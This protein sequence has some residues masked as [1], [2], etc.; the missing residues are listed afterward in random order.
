MANTTLSADVNHFPSITWH[1][2]HI[3]HGHFEGTVDSGAE[4]KI[5]SL[6]N[7]IVLQKKR[8]SEVYGNDLHVETQLG[9][10]FDSDI[11][12]MME[13]NAIPVNEFTVEANKKC[14]LPVKISYIPENGTFTAADTVIVAESGSESTFIFEYTSANDAGGVFGNR[15]RVH[16]AENAVVHI[17]TVNILGKGIVHY[18]GIGSMVS[19]SGRVDLIQIE[20]GGKETFSG[21]YHNLYGYK[22][23]C[24]VQGGYA[25]Q[26]DSQLDINYVA[27][28]SGRESDS[29]SF[30]N[31]VLM[32][33]AKKAWRGSIDF[34][35]DAKDAKGDEQENVLLLSPK[36]V[37]K[38]MPVILCDEE[39]VEGRHGGTI[40]RL[41]EDELLYLET[42]GIDEMTARSM[43]IKSKI[44]AVARFIPD[45]EVVKK[46]QDYLEENL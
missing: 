6:P 37:N 23:S 27:H 43:M 19:D 1:H 26:G 18:N 25:V 10:K 36:V 24:N 39:D 20:L 32:D 22:S 45:E 31:G 42:R 2:L 46:V 15:I 28:Q 34:E 9:K 5:S 8:L 38:S 21:S 13:S 33:N 35:R 11:D 44:N 3:N 7:C 14:L 29:F 12:G 4:A 17:V 30:F 40:G 41:G 16:C